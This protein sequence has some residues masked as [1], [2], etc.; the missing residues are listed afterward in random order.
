MFELFLDF[1]EYID[2][3]VILE[4]GHTF[5][6]TTRISKSDIKYT[7]DVFLKDMLKALGITNDDIRYLGSVG[8]KESSGDID[9]LINGDKI[10]D[11]FNI[12]N[13]TV[14]V[15]KKVYDIMNDIWGSEYETNYTAGLKVSNIAFPIYNAVGKTDSYV[16]IDIMVAFGKDALDLGSFIYHSPDITKG[17]SLY[18]GAHR[19]AFLL[20]LFRFVELPPDE[21]N[22]EYF[23]DEYGGIY[24]GGVKAF[25]KYSLLPHGVVKQRKSFEG[26]TKPLSTPKT[27]KDF[28]ELVETNPAKIATI[29]LGRNGSLEDLNSFETIYNFIESG[30]NSYFTKNKSDIYKAYIKF[31]KNKMDI[32]VE[33]KK[34]AK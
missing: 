14:E 11:K 5:K 9:I 31:I 15:P 26:I 3:K 1:N 19:S 34:Y 16:Q 23:N 17:E 25:S 2:S 8:K 12:S 7:M 24:K 18:S 21:K 13:K 10:A 27:L 33:L 28:D 29:V 6:G 20:L 30:K 4:G 22:E 32:P